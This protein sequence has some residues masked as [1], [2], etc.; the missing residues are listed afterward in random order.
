MV[1]PFS[2]FCGCFPIF[3]HALSFLGKSLLFLA[4]RGAMSL[5]PVWPLLSGL[6]DGLCIEAARLSQLNRHFGQSNLLYMAN[7]CFIR[8]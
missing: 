2:S 7:L 1:L 4:V 5:I 6:S 3:R 8:V